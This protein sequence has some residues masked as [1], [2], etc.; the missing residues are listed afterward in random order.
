MLYQSVSWL[1][2]DFPPHWRLSID[3]RC[4]IDHAMHY[5]GTN[6]L[7]KPLFDIIN[8]PHTWTGR[9]C[10]INNDRVFY[11]FVG[12]I[13]T[14]QVST[15]I[16]KIEVHPLRFIDT[17]IADFAVAETMP[18]SLPLRDQAI[19]INWP[20]ASSSVCM[21]LGSQCRLYQSVTLAARTV[22]VVGLCVRRG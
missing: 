14:W 1:Q 7:V 10:H 21:S 12:R 5:C 6:P 18:P 11:T 20:T 4:V 22:T 17:V 15:A 19:R 3:M 13:V 9:G 8:T 2:L 16:K